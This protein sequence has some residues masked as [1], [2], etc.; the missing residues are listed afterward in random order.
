MAKGFQKMTIIGN[1]GAEPSEKLKVIKTANGDQ[2]VLTVG[3]AVTDRQNNTEWFNCTFWGG[4]AEALAQYAGKGSTV[5]VEARRRTTKKETDEGTRFFE[6]YTVSEMSILTYKGSETSAE[7]EE[8]AQPAPPPA[9]APRQSYNRGS[10]NSGSS[11]KTSYQAPQPRQG[12]RTPARTAAAPT[13]NRR[14]SSNPGYDVNESLGFG[15]EED[16]S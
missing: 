6:E 13:T 7:E 2:A 15:P 16:F 9:P 11:G 4:L 1:L 12:S 10:G 8:Y 5:H 3:V 14:A